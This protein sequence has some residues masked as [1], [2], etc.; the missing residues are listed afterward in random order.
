M[1]TAL[2]V[3]V[4]LKV[5]KLCV[6]IQPSINDEDATVSNIITII[7]TITVFMLPSG[8]CRKNKKK[9]KQTRPQR[10]S[11]TASTHLIICLSL[12]LHFPLSCHPSGYHHFSVASVS[13]ITQFLNHSSPLPAYILPLSSRPV[14]PSAS[15][16]SVCLFLGSLS[17]L[18]TVVSCLL[19]PA[20]FFVAGCCLLSLLQC[21]PV[22][23]LP[24]WLL[25]KGAGM[26]DESMYE[27][28][29]CTHLV[30]PPGPISVIV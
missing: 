9:K 6:S 10:R 3:Q 14:I 11:P 26:E 1:M 20:V 17:L 15:L 16:A 2:A 13:S 5:L 7:I 25:L 19:S 8:N 27:I 29:T 30:L 12:S 4:Q 18:N 22:G 23:A 21:H 28:C 24:H